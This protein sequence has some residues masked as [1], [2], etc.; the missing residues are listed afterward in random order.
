MSCCSLPYGYSG[1][2][3]A[4]TNVRIS[5]ITC[6]SATVSWDGVD[7]ATRYRLEW[8]LINNPFRTSTRSRT[9]RAS[10]T[11]YTL[12]RLSESGEY[13]VQVTSLQNRIEGGTSPSVTFTA[14]CGGAAVDDGNNVNG[15][16]FVWMC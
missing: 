6:T 10:I 15:N 7:D 11:S 16:N 2:P 14:S 3:A 1:V 4:P 8:M 12:N 13:S 9:G 5:A